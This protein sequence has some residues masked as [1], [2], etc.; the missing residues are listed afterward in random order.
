LSYLSELLSQQTAIN[1]AGF[2]FES[3]IESLPDSQWNLQI[4]VML[5]APFHLIKRSLPAMKAKGM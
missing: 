5:T 1:A 2:W 3:P 4:G